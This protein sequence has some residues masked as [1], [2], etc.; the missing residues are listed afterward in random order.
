M[1][2]VKRA[3]PISFLLSVGFFILGIAVLS[4]FFVILL[5]ATTDT[6]NKNLNS[7]KTQYLQLFKKEIK[8]DVIEIQGCIPYLSK[9]YRTYI[10]N[11]MKLNCERAISLSH[12]AYSNYKLLNTKNKKSLVPKGIRFLRHYRKW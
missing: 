9:E 10:E 3:L 2:K 8:D 5:K 6:F 4:I 12:A 11:T 7:I 1:V